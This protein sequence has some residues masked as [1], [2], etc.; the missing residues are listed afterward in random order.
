MRISATPKQRRGV[1]TPTAPMTALSALTAGAIL[2]LGVPVFELPPAQAALPAFA[3][4]AQ[5]GASGAAAQPGR[6]AAGT[7][8]RQPDPI[9]F[10]DH[11]GWISLFDGKTLKNW[12]GSPEVWHVEDGAIVGVSSPEKPS[13]TTN[14]IYRGGEYG[15]FALKLEVKLEG[16]GAN[17][18]IQFRSA[19]VPPEPRQI[20]ADQLA[21]MSPEQKQRMQEMNRLRQKNAK[22]NIK[23]YQADIDSRNRWS[24]QIY[25]Q[26]SP[27]G[28]IAW[29]GQVVETA[30]GRNPRLIATLGDPEALAAYVKPNEWNQMEIIAIGN[31][32]TTII[33]GHVMASLIDND[34]AY[35]QAKGLIALEIEGPGNLRILH[36]NIWLKTF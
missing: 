21:Q 35:A 36:R 20:P 18:G 25:E 23:G 17:G 30:K 32:L 10:N 28:I 9:D 33:N 31:Q 8:F 2:L 12:D 24:G 4:Q 7:R 14:L 27:R 22:W 5:A 3:A 15:N 34:P 16:E 11:E 13:G 19:N 6:G 29:R 1:R 26:D